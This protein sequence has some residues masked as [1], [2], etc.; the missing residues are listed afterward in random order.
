MGASLSWIY[1][2][3]YVVTFN[4]GCLCVPIVYGDAVITDRDHQKSGAA[5]VRCFVLAA[6][7]RG[8]FVAA[9]KRSEAA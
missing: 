3:G 2:W 9:E 7:C 4:R 5:G 6:K 8:S 1:E